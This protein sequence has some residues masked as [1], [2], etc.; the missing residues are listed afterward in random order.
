[1][2]IAAR[3]FLALYQLFINFMLK[4]KRLLIAAGISLCASPALAQ[5][6][7]LGNDG[8]FYIKDNISPRTRYKVELAGTPTTRAIQANACG[9]IVLRPSAKQPFSNGERFEITDTAAGKTY[10]LANT[11]LPI[12]AS[13]KCKNGQ[14]ETSDV[15][16]VW[17]TSDGAIAIRGLT[18]NGA[19]SLRRLDQNS[20][21]TIA[22]N[23]CGFLRIKLPSPIPAAILLNGIA[24]P[25]TAEAS[26]PGVQCKKGVLYERYPRPPV[27]AGVPEATWKQQNS[28]AGTPGAIAIGSTA[29][30]PTPSPS[31]TPAPTP[32][33]SPLSTPVPAPTPSPTPSPT[34]TY[35]YIPAPPPGKS[36]C[37]SESGTSVSFSGLQPNR[38]YTAYDTEVDVLDTKTSNSQ[39]VVVFGFSQDVRELTWEGE[40]DQIEIVAGD[41]NSIGNNPVRRIGVTGMAT[42]TMYPINQEGQI[43]K[44]NPDGSVEVV[45]I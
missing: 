43:I 39:G 13:P 36:S 21:R 32:S 26:V 7:Q 12:K 17:K 33:S 6:G 9:M 20:Q 29:P 42:C 3:F 4:V 14:L 24:F 40:P 19:I 15:P 5:V 25:T 2:L 35:V 27:I 22:S 1:L 16:M 18:P 10:A 44:I 45:K 8:Y 28:T 34:P 30:T 23:D 38:Q 31:P 37:T 11:N 41:D